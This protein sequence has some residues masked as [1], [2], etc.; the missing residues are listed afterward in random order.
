MV[1][2]VIDTQK[3]ITDERLF[4]FR[5]LEENIRFLIRTA[6]ECGTEVVYVRHDDGPGSGFSKG[7]TAFEIYEGFAPLEGEKIFEKN[8][9]SAFHEST[10]LTAYLK[11][12]E[13]KTVIAVGLQTDYCMDATIK[14]GFEKGFEMIVPEYCNSTRSNAYM[15]AKATY[16]FYNKN[17]WPG[18]YAT[19]LSVEDT[20][21][22]IK[23][24]QMKETTARI[25]GCGTQEIETPRLRLRPFCLE[26]AESVWRNWAGDETVQDMYG[27]PVYKTPEEA[28][29]LLERYINGYCTGYT[30]RWGIFEKASGEC[31]G[32]VAYFLVDKN[33]SWGEIEYCIGAAYQGNGY[34]TE[35]TKA[36]IEYGFREIGFHKVQIC[37]RPSNSSS[38]RVIEKC[39]FEYEGTLRD[40]FF[41]NGAYEGRMYYSLLATERKENFS[42][43]VMEV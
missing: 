24:Y 31:I 4:A 36:V 32:Q 22:R 16:E 33:N 38:K 15:D 13:V 27:E 20:I 34:A 19:C 23:T 39:G 42:K 5:E 43:E 25:R 26:D 1:L 30:F 11:A 28:K 17:M 6:R 10:G 8:V 3:G 9:N 41:R 21:K 2:L 40:Y 14:S 18:R 35:A 29:K 7:D 37:V 12:K